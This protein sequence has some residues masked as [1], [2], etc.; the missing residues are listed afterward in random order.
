[1]SVDP[2]KLLEYEK[3][4]LHDLWQKEIKRR[5]EDKLGQLWFGLILGMFLGVYLTRLLM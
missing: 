4:I 5:R 1:M 3:D 2:I